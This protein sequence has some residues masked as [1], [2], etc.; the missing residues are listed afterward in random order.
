VLGR[1][2]TGAFGKIQRDAVVEL[3][4]I[5]MRKFARRRPAQHLGEKLR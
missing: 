4:H 1:E 2:G 3:D 5:E